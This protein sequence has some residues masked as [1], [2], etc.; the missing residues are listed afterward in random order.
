MFVDK[1][2]DYNCI[3]DSTLLSLISGNREHIITLIHTLLSI[4]QPSIVGLNAT[5]RWN[6][7]DFV[8]FLIVTCNHR[9]RHYSYKIFVSGSGSLPY[10]A[11]A[12]SLYCRNIDT[13]SHRTFQNTTINA[14]MC[15]RDEWIKLN[16]KKRI[17]KMFYKACFLAIWVFS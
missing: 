4:S 2:E 9:K 15:G 14:N 12:E 1:V 5:K 16:N 8:T 17:C 10:L 7:N 11:K 13:S 6:F 3:E